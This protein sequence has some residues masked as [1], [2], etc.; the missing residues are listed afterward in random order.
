M[1]AASPK[2]K[3]QSEDPSSIPGGAALCF[4]SSDPAVSSPL[5]DRKKKE[6]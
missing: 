5:S 1:L 2:P 3:I 6:V 4:I